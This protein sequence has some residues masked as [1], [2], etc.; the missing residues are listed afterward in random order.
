MQLEWKI[1]SCGNSG[2]FYL[3]KESE[4][5]TEAY[6]TGIEMQVLDNECH[7][8]G[9]L[10]TH[11][12]GDLYDMIACKYET[13]KPAGEWNKV[14]IRIKNG[15]V[16]Q[17]LNGYKVVEYQLWNDDWK[18]MVANSKFKD[19]AGFGASKKGHISLQEH[20]DRVWYRNIKIKELKGEI[21]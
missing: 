18:N 6:Y 5:Y 3:V 2:I 4:E 17:W 16:E 9:K 15:H 1:Q 8:D 13:V 14:R 21:N 12:A 20:D 11:R 19:W 10:I 7:K